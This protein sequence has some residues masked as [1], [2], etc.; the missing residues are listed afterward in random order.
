VIT[1]FKFPST[2]NLAGG[3]L[4]GLRDNI[5][6]SYVIYGSLDLGRPLRKSAGSS[7]SLERNSIFLIFGTRNLF[8]E[9]INNAMWYMYIYVIYCYLFL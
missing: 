3:A 7:M 9:S 4:C 2:D 8:Y 1:I 6:P 5:N